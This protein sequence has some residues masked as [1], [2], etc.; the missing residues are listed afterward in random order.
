VERQDAAPSKLDFQ[1]VLHREHVHQP[2]MAPLSL[3][4]PCHSS[5]S[6]WV[7]RVAIVPNGVPRK[8]PTFSDDVRRLSRRGGC[9]AASRQVHA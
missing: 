8:N 7:P 4:L 5:A 2:W 9:K 1:L 6:R 3:I